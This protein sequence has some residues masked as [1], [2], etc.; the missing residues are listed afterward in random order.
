MRWGRAVGVILAL[1]ILVAMRPSRA[2]ADELTTPLIISGA[3]AGG[4]AVIL[5]VAIL[6]SGDDEPELLDALAPLPPPGGARRAAPALRY[7][8]R[9]RDANGAFALLCW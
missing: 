6:A 4:V 8:S 9:C 1:L 2:R 3:V 5:L 7:G